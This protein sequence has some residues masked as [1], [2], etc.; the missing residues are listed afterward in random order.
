LPFGDGGGHAEEKPVIGKEG[1]AFK[2][3]KADT[4]QMFR[5][6]QLKRFLFLYGMVQHLI[7]RKR[8][9]GVVSRRTDAYFEPERTPVPRIELVELSTKP[10]VVFNE[11]VLGRVDHEHRELVAADCVAVMN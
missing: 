5:R 3:R 10:Y 2:Q 11:V 8:A 7:Q 1:T 6:Y 4:L 9:E